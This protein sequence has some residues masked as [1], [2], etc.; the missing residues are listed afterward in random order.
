MICFVE[1][2]L[3]VWTFNLILPTPEGHTLV[4][5]RHRIGAENIDEIVWTTNDTFAKTQGTEMSLPL[6]L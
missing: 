6:L 5:G 3:F 2:I 1:K 4:L